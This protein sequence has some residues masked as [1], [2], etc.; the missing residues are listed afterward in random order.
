MENNRARPELMSPQG[1]KEQ[2]IITQ[3]MYACICIIWDVQV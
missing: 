1:Q 3:A 2:C